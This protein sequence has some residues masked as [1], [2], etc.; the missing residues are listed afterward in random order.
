[1]TAKKEY[2]QINTARIADEILAAS[3]EAHT[4]ED[5]KMHVEPI[6]RRAFKDTGIDID[7]VAYEKATALRAK[8]DAVYGHLIIEYKGPGKLATTPGQREAKKQLQRYLGEEAIK[9]RPQ[10]E[11]FLK[12]AIGVSIDG[13]MIM[14]AR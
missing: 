9:Y 14:F 7:I 3:L 12:K 13:Q 1:M 6:L 4:E 5:L 2:W 8:M 10:E 11:A